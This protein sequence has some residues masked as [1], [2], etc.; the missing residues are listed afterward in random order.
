VDRAW[1]PGVNEATCDPGPGYFVAP[2]HP[3]PADGCS[4]GITALA[5][6]AEHDTH[7]SDTDVYGAIEAWSDDT[8]DSEPGRFILH[9]T[10]F[11]A[12][13]GK[14]VLLTVEEDWPAAKKAAVRTLAHEH[15]ADVCKRSHLED[16]AKEHGQLVSDELLAWAKEGEPEP[17]VT[18][19]GGGYFGPPSMFGVSRW[20]Q[21]PP[22]APYGG[23]YT[24]GRPPQPKTKKGICETLGYPGPPN[25]RKGRKGDRVKDRNGVIWQ[26]VKGGNPGLWEASE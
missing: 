12:Q 24:T 1:H 23:I 2:G 21:S 20:Q 19:G 22:A 3:A 9:G 8:P 14:V 15:E 10:G 13:Y 7:W 25:H 16:A 4:C 17:N 5:R 6:F 26:C 11:R 18:F